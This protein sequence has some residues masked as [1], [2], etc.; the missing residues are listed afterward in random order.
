MLHF[1]SL[2]IFISMPLK[3]GRN[4]SSA[5]CLSSGTIGATLSSTLSSY[6]SIAIS[7]GVVTRPVPPRCLE[8]ANETAVEVVQKL[9]EDW[10]NDGTPN[11]PWQY[12]LGSSDGGHRM[13]GKVQLYNVNLALIEKSL[14]RENRKVVWTRIA[15]NGY[16]SLFKTKPL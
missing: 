16:G 14:E 7:Y 12:A 9:W 10:G 1:R 4:S 11:A 6:P 5:F 8:L 15:R 3:D 13:K 2:S